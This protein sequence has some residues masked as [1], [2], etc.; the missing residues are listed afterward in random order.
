[1][2]TRRKH[3]TSHRSWP[4]FSAAPSV[5]ARQLPRHRC[6]HRNQAG[7]YGVAACIR[8]NQEGRLNASR[9]TGLG[10]R[11]GGDSICATD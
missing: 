4:A 5:S 1:M 2:I 6:A 8:P 10:G 3:S 7:P 9:P 11:S